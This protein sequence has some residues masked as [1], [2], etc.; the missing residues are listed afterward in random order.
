M[1]G[2]SEKGNF[3]VLASD[4]LTY[5][6]ENLT[7]GTTYTVELFAFTKKGRGISAY[8]MKNTPSQGTP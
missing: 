6:M 8:Q 3:T 4:E 2:F 5:R 7:P 1:K